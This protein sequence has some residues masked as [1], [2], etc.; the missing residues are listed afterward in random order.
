MRAEGLNSARYQ[1][2]KTAA[3]GL[4]NK[5]AKPTDLWAETKPANA[6]VLANSFA[7]YLAY[8]PG[9]ANLVKLLTGF[10]PDGN[11]NPPAAQQAFE[12][13]GWKDL[14]MLEAAWRKWA[15]TGK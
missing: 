15:T 9:A 8:G 4:A 13:A 12:A 1:K 5:G 6:D 2:H 10:R 7:E 3:R 14:A 11:G